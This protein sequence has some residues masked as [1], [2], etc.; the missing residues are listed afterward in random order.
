MGDAVKLPF[1]VHPVTGR[2]CFLLDREGEPIADWNTALAGIRAIGAKTVDGVI[3]KLTEGA[4]PLPEEGL[5]QET[6]TLVPRDGPVARLTQGC[7]VVRGLAERA[8]QTGHLRHT[9]QLILL[10]TAGH[11]GAEGAAFLHRTIAQCRNYDARICQGY[12]DRLEPAHPPVSCRRIREWLEEEGETRLCTCAQTCRTPLEH[13]AG[14]GR[15]AKAEAEEGGKSGIESVTVKGRRPRQNKPASSAN[16]ALPA[17]DAAMWTDIA[18]DL[19]ADRRE[20]QGELSLEWQE[21]ENSV[22]EGRE[23]AE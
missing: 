13:C 5:Q 14:A 23:A 22:Q 21:P 15:L 3:K 9:H 19:F 12:I 1:G 16:Y 4:G 8:R 6:D 17:L 2:R 7:S 10:Y 18:D 11:L 20:A